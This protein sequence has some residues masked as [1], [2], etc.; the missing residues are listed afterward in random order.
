MEQVKISS[1][2]DPFEKYVDENFCEIP[3]WEEIREWWDFLRVELKRNEHR[4]GNPYMD[5]YMIHEF[6]NFAIMQKS[7][8]FSRLLLNSVKSKSLANP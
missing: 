3:I 2:L 7:C 5:P 6:P 4:R 1:R 8:Y